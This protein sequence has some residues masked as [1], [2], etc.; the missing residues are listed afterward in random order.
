[1]LGL[2]N[3]EKW[4]KLQIKGR[5]TVL[6]IVEKYVRIYFSDYTSSFHTVRDLSQ[7]ERLPD[8]YFTTA[9]DISCSVL[10]KQTLGR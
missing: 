6:E 8:P 3:I 4:M 1:M 10:V 7:F 9:D 5:L 2:E